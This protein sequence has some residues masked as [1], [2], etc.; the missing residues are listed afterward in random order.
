MYTLGIGMRLKLAT[1]GG[2]IE[3]EG[4]KLTIEKAAEAE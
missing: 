3:A 4:G 2:M 1:V